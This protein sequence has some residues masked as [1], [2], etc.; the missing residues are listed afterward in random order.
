MKSQMN[1][2]TLTKLAMDWIKAR[3]A[4][5]S[6]PAHLSNKMHFEKS[7]EGDTAREESN[8][9]FSL[10]EQLVDASDAYDGD[11]NDPV[12][13]VV[14]NWVKAHK[15]AQQNTDIMVKSNVTRKQSNECAARME[16]LEDAEEKLIRLLTG[17]RGRTIDDVLQE[18]FPNIGKRR[19]SN[20]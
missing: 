12:F 6:N 10:T 5:Y 3:H 15:N 2:V 13:V 14:F 4:F 7:P 11:K 20:E 19:K 1:A 17:E 8:A 9:Y 18:N 16:V